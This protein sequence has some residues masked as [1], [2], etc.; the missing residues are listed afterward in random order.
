MGSDL[1]RYFTEKWNLE[2]GDGL[3]LTH[4]WLT[5]DSVVFDVGAYHGTWS[6]HMKAK[7]GCE[8]YLFEPVKEHYEQIT[9]LRETD[10]TTP[11]FKRV[12]PFGFASRSGFWPIYKNGTASSCYRVTPS[13]EQCEFRDVF[14]EVQE[15]LGYKPLALCQIDLMSINIE[16]GEY[17]LLPAMIDSKVVY[18]CKEIMVQFHPIWPSSYDDMNRIRN[19]LLQTHNELWHYPYVW[20]KYRRRIP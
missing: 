3:I 8:P 12:F 6:G 5:K 4:S 17:D 2:V 15:V 7:Y 16:G 1:Q 14:T 13:V 11:F 19:G 9:A 18:Q 20:S 10:R